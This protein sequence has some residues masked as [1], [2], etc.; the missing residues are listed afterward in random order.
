MNLLLLYAS[1]N[2]SERFTSSP[3][4][5]SRARAEKNKLNLCRFQSKQTELAEET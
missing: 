2:Q 4:P 5:L 1:P 3:D